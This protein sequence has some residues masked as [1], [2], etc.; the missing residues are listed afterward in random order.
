[1]ATI[2]YFHSPSPSKRI[3]GATT[4]FTVQINRFFSAHSDTLNNGCVFTLVSTQSLISDSF[5]PTDL[6][7]IL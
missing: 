5:H 6:I 2:S 7:P 4:I 1:M 3:V